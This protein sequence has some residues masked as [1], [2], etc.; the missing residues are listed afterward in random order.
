MIQR[1][2]AH[3]AWI[4]C[5]SFSPVDARTLAT[6]SND[7]TVCIWTLSGD[8]KTSSLSRQLPGHTFPVQSTAWSSDGSFLVSGSWDT[9]IRKWNV[10]TGECELTIQTPHW[11]YAVALSPDNKHVVSGGAS[12]SVWDVTTGNRILGPL[13]GH[14]DYVFMVAYSPDGRRI[15][16]GSVDNSIVIWDSTN[17]QT[18]FR[19]L[20][21]HSDTVRSISFHPSGKKFVTGSDDRTLVVWDANTFQPI[22][23]NL[24]Y[25]SAGV[26]SVQYSPDGR[27]ILSASQDGTLRLS[28]TKKGRPTSDP[29]QNGCCVFTAAFSPDGQW[30]ASGGEDENV[31]IWGVCELDT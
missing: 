2:K 6:S 7:G 29:V 23:K 10:T 30:V 22:R 27:S 21:A 12:V 19:P 25:H 26:F 14:K 1:F 18:L 24:R 5:V 11:V 4:F 8:G 13:H 3:S 31:R 15:L 17:G 9:T 28:D 20:A 16:S